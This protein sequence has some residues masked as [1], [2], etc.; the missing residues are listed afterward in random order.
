MDRC[1]ELGKYKISVQCLKSYPCQHSITD[2]H[3]GITK[4]LPGDKIYEMLTTDGLGLSHF[5]KYN[6]HAQITIGVMRIHTS[7]QER[8]DIY[9][10]AE[11]YRKKLEEE[12]NERQRL[13]NIYKASTYIERLKNKHL[14]ECTK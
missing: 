5:D 12:Y 4:I 6:P 2:T 10:Q 1:Y 9:L 8:T 7:Q 3:T 14:G 13:T 11:M